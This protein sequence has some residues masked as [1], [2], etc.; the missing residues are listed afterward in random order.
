MAV[1]G[2]RLLG[3]QGFQRSVGGIAFAMGANFVEFVQKKQRI[4]RFRF[5]Y[6]GDNF[7]EIDPI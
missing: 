2:G 4:G 7:P 3:I 5:L 1:E 6:A